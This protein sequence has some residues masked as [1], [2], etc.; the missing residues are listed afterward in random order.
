MKDIKIDETK[1][2]RDVDSKA[3][4]NTNRNALQNYKIARKKKI[5]E[6][7]DINNMKKDI[8]ELKEMIK[9]LLGKQHG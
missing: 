7:N 5:D 8:A 9:T 1:Y 6:V 4:L 3:I 2:V